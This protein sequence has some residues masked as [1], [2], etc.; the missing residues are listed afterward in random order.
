MCVMLVGMVLS[1]RNVSMS[2]SHSFPHLLSSLACSRNHD[3]SSCNKFSQ[4][5]V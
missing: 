2:Y 4:V 5:S 3:G 1:V